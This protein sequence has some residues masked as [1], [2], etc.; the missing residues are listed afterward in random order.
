[1]R[2]RFR[3]Q[4]SLHP[5]TMNPDQLEIDTVDFRSCSA[6][7]T[8]QRVSPILSR[9]GVT[10]VAKQT[11]LDRIGVPV[12]C[13]YTP[14]A[15]AIVIAQGKGID[16]E[17]AKTSAVMEAVERAVAASPAC[18]TISDTAF[19]LRSGGQVA[20]RL[21]GLLAVKATPI[22]DDETVLWARA[23]NLTTG[24][25]VW[26]PAEAIQLDRTRIAPRF[27]QS[28]DGLASG[29]GLIEATLHGLLE[30]V[31]RDAMT[32]WQITTS[33]KRY[34]SRID[35]DQIENRDLRG[36]LDKISAAAMEIAIFDM[37]S[38][39]AIPC[40]VAL[41]KPRHQPQAGDSFRHVD[42]TLGA[43]CSISPEVA[44]I[45]AITEAVQSRMTFIAGARDDVLP[46]TFSR[47]ANPEILAAFDAPVATHIKNLPRLDANSAEQALQRV[48]ERL[49]TKGIS[50][51][52]AA[53]ISPD[54]LPATVVKVVV[55]QLENP[56]G[57]RR[58]RFGGRAI[59]RALQ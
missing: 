33:A 48:I 30:R 16:D 23:T 18:E 38:D 22:R 1:L 52:Y 4:R 5:D 32:L 35:A 58:Q 40:A 49:Q 59:S 37:T 12:W 55:P 14:N 57:E 2:L 46:S 27:W 31:E 7:E 13:A 34:Q 42:I 36:L 9:L 6:G 43:G 51:I 39:L 41:L 56:E 10:R 45:R 19:S 53:D 15:K 8:F 54:W 25:K 44:A 3:L 24:Q 26:L 17:A 29:N 50:D 11:S 21:N 28:S 47:P 20:N